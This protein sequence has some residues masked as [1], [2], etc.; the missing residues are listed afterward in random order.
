MKYFYATALCFLG[1]IAFFNAQQNVF[2]QFEI[3]KSKSLKHN[4][5]IGVNF[6]YKQQVNDEFKWKKTSLKVY[7]AKR[8]TNNWQVKAGV[9]NLYTTQTNKDN[10][11]E[12]RPY[13]GP[14]LSVPIIKRISFE[15]EARYEVRNFFYEKEKQNNEV[16]NRFR[17]KLYFKVLLSKN[18]ETKL[19]WSVNVGYE[20]FFVREPNTGEQFSNLREFFTE[21]KK[22]LKNGHSI[23]FNYYLDRVNEFQKPN[24]ANNHSFNISYTF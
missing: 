10:F 9:S 11:Y 24:A 22:V 15:Q 14:A 5:S 17:Y 20:W 4:Y 16:Q 3:D 19:P 7:G 21:V 6:C 23:S 2:S 18:L 12:L 8:L 13:I 1:Y